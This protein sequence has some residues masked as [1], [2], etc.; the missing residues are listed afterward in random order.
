MLG[1]DSKS[2]YGKEKTEEA[3]AKF[4]FGEEGA[5]GK[6]APNLEGFQPPSTPLN[7]HAGDTVERRNPAPVNLV[8]Y[9]IIYQGFK[10]IPGGFLAGFRKNHQQHASTFMSSFWIPFSP[11]PARM[12]VTSEGFLAP[13][14]KLQQACMY[15]YTIYI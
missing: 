9:S 6:Q 15:I 14:S 5:S 4:L 3:H 13:D 8:V 12:D 11:R 10:N 7:N 1:E 2:R